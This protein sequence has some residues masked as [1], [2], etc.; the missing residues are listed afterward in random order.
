MAEQGYTERVNAHYTPDGLA[1]TVVR[2]LRSWGKEDATLTPDDL[3]PIDQFHIGG[4]AA[5]LAL[6]ALADI[7]PTT[8]VLDV[9]GGFGGPARTLAATYGCSVVVLDLTE[10]YCQVGEMLTA[11]SGLSERV[12]FRQGDARAIPFPDAT[13]DL[14]WTQHSSMNIANKRQLYAET[15][16][17]LRPGGRLAL[18]EIMAGPYGPLHFPVPWARDASISFLS[19]PDDVHA[20]LTEIGYRTLHWEDLTDATV[21]AAQSRPVP[22]EPPPGLHLVLGADFLERMGNM[23]RNRAEHRMALV[24]AVL[25]RP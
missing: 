13:F 2:L 8:R 18:Y 14:V 3:A 7:G 17:V 5:T 20:L 15:Y 10:A 11:R 6:A 16:R 21:A 1:D 19:P 23:Q 22:V 12:V 25:A 9:G 4:K 24:R